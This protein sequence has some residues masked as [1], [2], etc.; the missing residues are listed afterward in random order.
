M[1]GD[2][3]GVRDAVA[4]GMVAMLTRGLTPA[5]ALAQAQAQADRAI[6]EYNERIGA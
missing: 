1:I 2:Y 3:Q 4:D 6:R 5:R